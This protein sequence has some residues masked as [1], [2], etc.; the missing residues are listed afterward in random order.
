MATHQT[1]GR[2]HPQGPRRDNAPPAL[3][4]PKPFPLLDSAGNPLPELLDDK[5][6]GWAQ[7]FGNGLKTSQMR[8]F[9]DEVKAIERRL[10]LAQTAESADAAFARERAGLALLKAKS[11]YAVSREVAPPAFNQFV[12]DAVASIKTSADFR[13]FVKLFEAIVAYHRFLYPKN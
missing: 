6:R 4:V 13:A 7:E 12:F 11:A 9:F 8:R 10:D 5:A 1:G 2:G 3:P